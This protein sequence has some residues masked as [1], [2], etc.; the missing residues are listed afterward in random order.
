MSSNRTAV[1]PLLSLLLALL[2]LVTAAT[3]AELPVYQV[4]MLIF[5]HEGGG[6][7]AKGTPAQPVSGIQEA[8]QPWES[9]EEGKYFHALP[10]S[11]LMLTTASSILQK[12]PDY[13]V[14]EHIAWRQP[15]LGENAAK[16]VHIH[17][18]SEYSRSFAMPTQ[19]Y[20]S[21]SLY[22]GTSGSMTLEQLDGTVKV[23]LGQYL[24]LYT[25]LVLRK[26]V[27]TQTFDE[28]Q[29]PRSINALYQFRI[30]DHRLMRS[31]ELHY[32]DHPL[33]GILVQIT[34]VQEQIRNQA[35][36]IM[37]KGSNGQPPGA[38]SAA[39]KS[40]NQETQSDEDQE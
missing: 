12:S 38:P 36:E 23:V 4:E 30:Q 22:T 16:A 37:G 8:E 32:I 24:H 18:G 39:A 14:I 25:D 19:V 29:Q 21:P 40:G 17:G 28:N 6:P 34:P 13:E 3:G 35:S 2:V 26:P 31:R 10:P 5:T 33:L 20:K 11:E 27:Y 9:Q 15:G 7:L 1:W